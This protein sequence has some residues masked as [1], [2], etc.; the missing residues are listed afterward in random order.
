MQ[1]D[2]RRLQVKVELMDDPCL[3]RWEIRDAVRG[4]I[5]QSSWDQEWTA[6]PSREEAYRAG[7]DRLQSVSTPPPREPFGSWRFG[8]ID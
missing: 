1:C 3:W 4:A 8:A 5:V 2:P 7:Q 6:Y